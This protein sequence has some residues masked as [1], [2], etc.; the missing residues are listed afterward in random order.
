MTNRFYNKSNNILNEGYI[1]SDNNITS[2]YDSRSLSL[3]N[4]NFIVK[5]SENKSLFSLKCQRFHNY[6]NKIISFNY[7]Q[8]NPYSRISQ[9]YSVPNM[10]KYTLVCTSDPMKTKKFFNNSDEKNNINKKIFIPF[11]RK[12]NNSPHNLSFT[13]SF[14]ENR[15]SNDNYYS[16]KNNKFNE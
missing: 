2:K 6:S 16:C 1:D 5:E 3:E 9:I 4:I 12:N 14:L 11:T 10:P 15:N 7:M 8:L 13:K